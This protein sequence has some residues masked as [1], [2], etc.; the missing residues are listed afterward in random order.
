M[1]ATKSFSP[2]EESRE[3]AFVRQ[4]S[5]FRE[6]VARE[7]FAAGR[8]HL[9]IAKACPWAHRALIVRHLKRLD[10]AITVSFV[11]PFRDERGWAFPGG[12]Y[13][14]D[15][16]GWQFLAEGYAA[17]DPSFHGRVTVP[18]LWDKEAERIVNN[19]SA[20]II[21]MLDEW[22]DD[23]PSLYPE[24]LRG[25]IDAVNERVYETVNNGVYRAGFAT[26]QRAYDEAYEQ[27]FASLDWLEE[28]LAERRYLVSDEIPT[29]AD[30]RLFTT[31]VRFD[32][33]Y[34]GH[35]KCNRNRIVDM[36]NL[37][38]FARDLYQQPGIAETVD[39]G[40][41]KAHY[42][43]THPTLN[44]TGI[45]PRGPRIDFTTPHGRDGRTWRPA[46]A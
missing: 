45:V 2:A 14:D 9:Y 11:A 21:R 8:F 20:D 19:E 39:L 12:A 10:D 26:S 6:H 24:A 23:G 13:V 5:A 25:E 29:E 36:P 3:G 27:L 41:I 7:D 30:W 32:P 18:V 31:L 17:T 35:F 1:S 34:V 16:H 28:R 38:G 44:P 15:L 4:K 22:S 43:G 40:Q 37:W 42:Y 46:A 33:V